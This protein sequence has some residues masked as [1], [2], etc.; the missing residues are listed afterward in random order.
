MPE[1]VSRS[2]QTTSKA[3]SCTPWR[4]KSLSTSSAIRLRL[5]GQRPISPRLFSSMSRMT[6]RSSRSRGIV[7]ARRASYMMLSSWVTKPMRSLRSASP[8][9]NSV[10]ARPRTILTTCCLRSALSGL[11]EEFHLDAGQFDDVVV[12]EGMGRG[13][14]FLAVDGG[15]L[16]AFDVGDE[17]ALRPAGE[18]R[19]LHAG[20]AERSE[21]LGEL[22]LPAGVAA[23]QELDRAEGLP[24]RLRRRC[25]SGRS[26]GCGRRGGLGA[27]ILVGDTGR[28]CA[29]RC[30]LHRG[31]ALRDG[32]LRAAAGG[33]GRGLHRG[34]AQDHRFFEVRLLP[35][36]RGRGFT[37]E[38]ELVLAQLDDVVVLQEVLLDRVAVDDRAVGAAEV[39][40]ERVVEYRDDHGVLAAYRKVV[41][42]DVVVGLAADG[43][44]LLRQGELLE[45]E[46]IHA[47]YQFRHRWPLREVILTTR[48]PWP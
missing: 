37:D 47:E 33:S 9:K 4:S 38:L 20:L 14:D 17:V 31:L 7:I 40:E 18:H 24:P 1:L 16:R 13:A 27:R 29:G 44:A 26:R 36:G 15:T 22:E 48:T 35:A 39:L 28:R 10:I 2:A 3:T 25:R 21:G 32:R 41:D 42:L 46:P 34:G 5:Q 30:R 23:G 45:N 8:T 12:L 6:M 43:G 19:D 11:Q